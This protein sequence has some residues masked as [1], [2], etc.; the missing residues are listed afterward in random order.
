MATAKIDAD[1]LRLLVEDVE[2]GL[3]DHHHIMAPST[4]RKMEQAIKDAR[5]A[6]RKAS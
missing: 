6:L 4:V 5:K 1:T 3:N 2:G